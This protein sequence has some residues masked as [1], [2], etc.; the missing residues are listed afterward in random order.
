MVEAQLGTN[1]EQ[2]LRSDQVCSSTVQGW[3]KA[4][5]YACIRETVWGREIS[6]AL[7]QRI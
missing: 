3:L 5:G 2:P 1:A 6:G 7:M 4:E